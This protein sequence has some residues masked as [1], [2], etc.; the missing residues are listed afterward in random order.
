MYAGTRVHL[1]KCIL[2]NFVFYN[3]SK[4]LG[5]QPLREDRATLELLKIIYET[6]T[7]T[8]VLRENIVI[9]VFIV[10]FNFSFH[11]FSWNVGF[12]PLKEDCI[13]LKVI[14][15]SYGNITITKFLKRNAARGILKKL[16]FEKFHI[17]QLFRESWFSEVRKDQPTYSYLTL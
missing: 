11:N 10:V 1:K 13:T 4:Y 6:V 14:K 16:Y 7:L 3:F 5:S 15:I 2:R 9:V 17:L 8:K 12:Q